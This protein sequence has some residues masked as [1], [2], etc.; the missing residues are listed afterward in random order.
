MLFQ[1]LRLKNS[2]L[3]KGDKGVVSRPLSQHRGL[4]LREAV[5]D[6]AESTEMCYLTAV[7]NMQF[8]G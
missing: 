7:V 6:G 4:V 8:C 2:P 3:E 1:V 5:E